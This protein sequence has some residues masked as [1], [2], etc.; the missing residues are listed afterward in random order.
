M[1]TS[2]TIS[3]LTDI[4][5][6][7]APSTIVPVVDM[8]G[9]LTT[10][11]ANLQIVGNLILNGAGG[12]SFAAAAKA[13]TAG[14]VTTAAQPNITSVG[15]LIGLAVN[16]TS[17]LGDISGVKITGGDSTNIL[18]T[19]GLGNLSW[20]AGGSGS[21]FGNLMAVDTTIMPITNNN[22]VIIQ[23]ATGTPPNP[24]YWYSLYGDLGIELNHD[25]GEGVAYDL[26]GNIYVVGGEDNFGVASF[27]VKYSPT[28][29]VLWQKTFDLVGDNKSGESVITDS[30]GNVYVGITDY[31]RNSIYLVKL[32]PAGVILWQNEI[33]VGRNV[34]AAN[35]AVD[36]ADNVY[37]VVLAYTPN[38]RTIFKFDSLGNEV[39][40]VENEFG[41]GLG[42]TVDGAGNIYGNAP[43]T[44]YDSLGVE[45]YQLELP[46][47][48][49]T[50][51]VVSDTAGNLYV[52]GSDTF[53]SN[54]KVQKLDPTGSTIWSSTF[55]TE[56]AEVYG[57]TLDPLNNAVLITG[58]RWAV[59]DICIAS[60]DATTGALNWCNGFGSAETEG[61][62]YYY[63]TNFI[64]T[65]G[66]LL[67][68][69]CYTSIGATPNFN[70]MTLQVATDGTG[71]N[72]VGGFSYYPIT[73]T[74]TVTVGTT[75]PN[76]N[77]NAPGTFAVAPGTWTITDYTYTYVTTGLG[78]GTGST[79]DFEFGLTGGLG[80]PD[81]SIQT[82]ALAT[83][84]D[85]S[86][87]NLTMTGLTLTSPNVTI[88][89]NAGVTT[90][91]VDGIAI[92]NGAGN[93]QQGANAIAIGANAG[94]TSQTANSIILNATGAALDATVA[95]FH[96]KPVRNV[97]TSKMMYY[98]T[99][100]GE[101]TYANPTETVVPG[102][103]TG[104]ATLTPD[105]NLGT[106]YNYT[107]TGDVTLNSLANAVAG[108]SALLVLTQ[109]VVG[110]RLLTSTMKFA[111]GANTLS[112]VAGAV[113][114]IS[115][116]YDGATYY[117][118]LTLA[119]A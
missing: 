68:V 15:E 80:F 77:V 96:V 103:N 104:A 33:Q 52:C 89:L 54:G 114:T 44:K 41:F 27:L 26:N 40:Q 116:L 62:W 58:A 46:D 4:G 5:A 3:E 108:T 42:V 25:Y 49:N 79:Y 47:F 24:L 97:V 48:S 61:Q 29:V 2:T 110:G 111:G 36:S 109:D 53:S 1:A 50:Y 13:T 69:T 11:K 65:I 117:A 86:F 78:V 67:S 37:F 75:I 99:T 92:G 56:F 91:G 39:F 71:T 90:Q 81:A 6:N 8:T 17:S 98:D 21:S 102:G 34:N 70:V 74:V 88:G 82:T 7:I 84:M 20:V 95:G 32:T 94:V 35:L 45:Q 100:S 63:G 60:L 119:Y 113:D 12:S 10:H 16:G 22:P 83:G 51:N 64:S 18:T 30:T 72:T 19:D 93:D 31:T 101:I 112:T 85:F 73:T 66:S 59:S 87:G 105:M 38:S 106:V 9:P 107:L 28:G 43:V 57:I 115:I 14:T 118:T 76:T 23:T 55:D